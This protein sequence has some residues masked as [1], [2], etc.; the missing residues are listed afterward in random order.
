MFQQLLKK[1]YTISNQNH[2]ILIKMVKLIFLCCK[3]KYLYRY[4]NESTVLLGLGGH[5]PY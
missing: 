5:G 1:I 4:L 3:Y 2:H